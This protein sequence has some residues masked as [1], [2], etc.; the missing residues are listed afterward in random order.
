MAVNLNRITFDEMITKGKGISLVD[1]WAP[2]C[3]PCRQQVPIVDALAD[4]ISKKAFVGKV[5]VEE[6]AILSKMF[7]I[8][9]IPTL[10]VFKDGQPVERMSGLHTKPQLEEAIQRHL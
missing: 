3:G 10:I 9:S 1:F 8:I 4:E 2:W 7:D 5:N 6:E